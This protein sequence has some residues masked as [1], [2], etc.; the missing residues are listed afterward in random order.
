MVLLDT[1]IPHS[2]RPASAHSHTHPVT[3]IRHPHTIVVHKRGF[4]SSHPSPQ[5]LT[6]I[7][8]QWRKHRCCRCASPTMNCGY[9]S[10]FISSPSFSSPSPFPFLF[11]CSLKH[12]KPPPSATHPRKEQ[13]RTQQMQSNGEWW[14]EIHSFSSTNEQ[15]CQENHSQ[16]IHHQKNGK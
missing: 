12:H 9:I 1:R 10:Q 7:C 4:K 2:H 13:D 11:P 16:T 3:V 14:W 6:S 5:R 8:A 15:I